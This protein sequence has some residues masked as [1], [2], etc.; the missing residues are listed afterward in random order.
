MPVGCEGNQGAASLKEGDFAWSLCTNFLIRLK[1][2]K[3]E[4]ILPLI[5]KLNIK[6]LIQLLPKTKLSR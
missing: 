5:N 1:N 2:R 4:N 3:K 6:I